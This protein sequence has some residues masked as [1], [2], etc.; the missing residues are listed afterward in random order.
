MA[1][2]VIISLFDQDFFELI[3]PIFCNYTPRYLV[4]GNLVYSTYDY[5][6]LFALS[7]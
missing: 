6:N 3:I 5:V 2:N 7:T 4:K 1:G